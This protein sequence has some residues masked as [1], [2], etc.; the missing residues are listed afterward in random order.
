MIVA[1]VTHEA[2]VIPQHIRARIASAGITLKCHNCGKEHDELLRFAGDADVIWFWGDAVRVTPE[3]LD[4]LPR[5]KALFRS[6]SGVDALPCEAARK[7][8][9]AICNTPDSIAEAVA[10]HAVTL[11]LSLARLIPQQDRCTRNG[12]WGVLLPSLQWHITGRTLGL[13]GYGRIARRVEKMLSGFNLKTLYY[14]PMVPGSTPLDDVLRQA[15]F[16]SLHCPLTAE[17]RNLIGERELGL[18]KPKALLVNTSRGAVVNEEALYHALKNGVIGGA[19]LDVMVQEPFDLKSPLFTLDNLIV[20]PH[21]AAFSADFTKNFWEY[22][23]AKL[24]E[25]ALKFKTSETSNG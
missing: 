13:V 11:L 20:T 19:A 10:E 12:Q 7:R 5:C 21:I 3:M 22:S 17:T 23:A 16:V 14:D 18:M 15:D 6:G 9:I 1:F 25:L 2:A 4:K 24:E 8:G